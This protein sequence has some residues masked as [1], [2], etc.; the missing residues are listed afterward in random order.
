[1]SDALPAGQRDYSGVRI[2]RHALE[3]F[4]E[5][6]LGR[7][8]GAEGEGLSAPALDWAA[9]EAELREALRR[10]RR[11]GRNPENGAVAVLGLVRGRVLVAVVQGDA[12]LTVLT[13]AQFTPRLREF[14]RS[15]PPRKWGRML[16]RLGG[17]TE[18]D[19]ECED[20]EGGAGRGRGEA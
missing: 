5:R 17:R 13:W 4:V 7:G 10:V 8:S 1:M 12:C 11:L 18:F 2:T 19:D 16:R 14:G 9:T 15:R 6:F 3:R 20:T